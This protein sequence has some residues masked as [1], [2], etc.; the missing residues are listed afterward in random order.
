MKKISFLVLTALFTFQFHTSAQF[1]S[2]F[3]IKGGITFSK[4]KFDSKTGFVLDVKYITGFNGSVFSEF[5]NSKTVNLYAEAGYDRRGYILNVI[6]TDEFGNKIGEYDVKH[7][8]N[9]IFAS[10]GAKL[11]FPTKHVIP[12]IL[13]GTRVDFYLGYSISSPEFP[14]F[15]S[16]NSLLEDLK[17][18]MF[19]LGA[20][21]GI[22]FNR[23]L[24]YRTFIEAN[25]QPGIITSYSNQNLDI[26]EHTFNIKLGIN[27]IKDKKK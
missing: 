12:Y 27:F 22:Q 14:E 11:K 9:Y 16:K 23:L 1:L 20:G 7:S 2:G 6:R 24:P 3:G 18:V 4:L 25:F 13:L 8:T 21:A 5:L 19:D 10:V 17:K 26:W 15:W